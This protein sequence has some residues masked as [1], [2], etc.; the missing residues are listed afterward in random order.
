MTIISD[1]LADRDNY[2]KMNEFH[3]SSTINSHACPGTFP[4]EGT[5]SQ[6]L[7]KTLVR[8]GKVPR[9][10]NCQYTLNSKGYRCPEFEDINWEESIVVFGCSN[11]MGIGLDDSETYPHLMQEVLKRPVINLGQGGTGIWQIVYNYRALY[12]QGRKPYKTVLQ[13]PE[14]NRL[15]VF[16]ENGSVYNLGPWENRM[17][18]SKLRNSEYME[19]NTNVWNTKVYQTMALELIDSIR[20]VD[21]LITFK[22]NDPGEYIDY[23]D[24]ARDL[25]HPG[26]R[27]AERAAERI[28]SII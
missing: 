12:K 2:D 15:G 22:Y 27:T 16:Y 7:H 6:A 25:S 9:K 4:F 18:R 1:F 26:P 21:C 28:L 23:V 19:Y 24:K 17:N 14:A 3:M 20:P 13:I 5:D 10:R 11:T 8:K